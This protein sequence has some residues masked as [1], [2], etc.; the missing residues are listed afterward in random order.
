MSLSFGGTRKTFNYEDK[1]DEIFYISPG[2]L[3]ASVVSS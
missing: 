2:L 1:A 3:A